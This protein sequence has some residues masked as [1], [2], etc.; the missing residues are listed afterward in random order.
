MRVLQKPLNLAGQMSN[1]VGQVEKCRPW[2]LKQKAADSF[3]EDTAA[4]QTKVPLMPFR[5]LR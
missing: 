2:K 4:K 3:L 1:T 5:L